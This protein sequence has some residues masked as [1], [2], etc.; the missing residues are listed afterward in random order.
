MPLFLGFTDMNYY[1]AILH[2]TQATFGDVIISL[3]AFILAS[4]TVKNR[5]WIL[6]PNKTSISLFFGVGIVITIIFELLA[7]GQ[8]NRWQYGSL[9]PIIPFTSIGIS[10]IAQWVILPLVQLWLVKRLLIAEKFLSKS[11]KNN[12]K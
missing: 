9:M 5:Q 8:L 3:S 7:T 4:L 6:S 1:A 2:C 12:H 10:P 11:H